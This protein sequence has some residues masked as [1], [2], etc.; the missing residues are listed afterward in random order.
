VTAT[1]TIDPDRCIG[2]GVS[3]SVAPKLVAI[4][5][6]APARF[7]AQPQSETEVE[8]AEAARVLCPVGAISAN[9]NERTE[10]R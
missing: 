6:G 7:V 8:M 3:T 9:S 4:T 5:A 2:C 1:Y 10:E